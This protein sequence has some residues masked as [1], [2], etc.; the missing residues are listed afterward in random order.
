MVPASSTAA[1]GQAE[2]CDAPSSRLL[3]GFD[4]PY[5]GHTG[6]Q[7]GAGGSADSP[8]RSGDMRVEAQMGLRWTLIPV[9]W[10]KLEPNG[11]EH[12]SYGEGNGPWQELDAT[13]VQA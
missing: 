8:D 7:D 5:I 6:S 9:F 10:S 4:S 11:P 1:S 2:R 12:P 13:I 3:G